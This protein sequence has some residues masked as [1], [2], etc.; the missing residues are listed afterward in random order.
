MS[1]IAAVVVMKSVVPSTVVAVFF[2]D[3]TTGGI[4]VRI[5]VTIRQP[6]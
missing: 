5:I 3:P 2:T 1:G 4:S 6:P